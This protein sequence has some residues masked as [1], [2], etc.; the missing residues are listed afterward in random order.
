MERGVRGRVERGE[1]RARPGGGEFRFI[2]ET[3]E[4]GGEGRVQIGETDSRARA[5]F[6]ALEI[7]VK[8]QIKLLEGMVKERDEQLAKTQ[9]PSKE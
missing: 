6:N 2:Q 3:I 1:E 5:K 9:P 4:R 7:V 8:N